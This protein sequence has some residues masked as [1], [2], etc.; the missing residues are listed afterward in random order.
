MMNINLSI[1]IFLWNFK[2]FTFH[3]IDGMIDSCW[4]RFIHN[5]EWNWIKS[6]VKLVFA[7]IIFNLRNS[8]VGLSNERRYWNCLRSNGSIVILNQIAT[9]IWNE[10]HL[11]LV[12][13]LFEASFSEYVFLF[14]FV[15]FFYLIINDFQI[16]CG[17]FILMHQWEDVII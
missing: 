17:T 12:F 3:V 5:S 14:P 8:D 10:A 1:R 9:E 7:Q 11:V 16:L 6:H 2:G 13:V 4:M 15:A